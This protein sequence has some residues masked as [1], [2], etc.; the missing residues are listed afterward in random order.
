VVV[1]NAIVLLDYTEK[2]RMW[3]RTKYE[4][5]IEAGKTRFRPVILTAL[6]TVTGIIPLAVGWALDIHTFKFVAGG[7]STQWWAPMAVV[8]IYGLSFAT[9]L[10][11]VV[12]PSMYMILGASD[13]EFEKRKMRLALKK[14]A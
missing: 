6:V 1:N 14:D 5:V 8:I 13:E 2:L 4:A 11:L 3:G 9:V 7:S 10:T 12:V